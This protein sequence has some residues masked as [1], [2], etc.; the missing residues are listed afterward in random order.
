VLISLCV[1]SRLAI[2]DLLRP[3]LNYE[4]LCIPILPN[5]M[6]EFLDAP[7]PYVIVCSLFRSP[8]ITLLPSSPPFLEI[9]TFPH[10]RVFA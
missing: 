5:S 8:Y 6:H 4:G 7:V 9:S 1:I 2:V 10:L 3:H